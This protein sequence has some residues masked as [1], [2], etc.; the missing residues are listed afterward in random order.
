PRNLP[1]HSPSRGGRGARQA[2]LTSGLRAAAHMGL[3]FLTRVRRT[4]LGLSV[5]AGLFAAVYFSY[6]TGAAIAAGAFWSLANF[7]LIER[8]VVG[9]T[10][11]GDS[12]RLMRRIGPVLAANVGLLGLGAVLLLKLPTAPLATG[13]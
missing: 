11:P 6:A 3:E 7:W 13:F 4:A 2:P 1:D 5:L 12:R 9:F 8:L 10:S